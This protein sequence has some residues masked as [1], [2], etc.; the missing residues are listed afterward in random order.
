MST[1]H[2]AEQINWN[3]DDLY[4][5]LSSEAFINDKKQ[6]VELA[7]A[8][9]NKWKGT[10]ATINP[11]G[12]KLLL[13]EYSD[14][15]DLLSKMSS[16]VYLVWSTNTIETTHGKAL[17][18][19]GDLNAGL[20]QHLVFF[21]VEWVAV[22]DEK[23]NELMNASILTHEK[24]FLETARKSK[25]YMLDESAEKVMVAKTTTARQ[26]WIRFF[27]ELLGAAEFELD[28]KTL[29]EQEVLS[30]LH[31]SDRELRIRAAQSL[32]KTFKGLSRQL[33][34]I[35]NTVLQDKAANDGLRNY[36]NW[37]TSRHMSNQID[38]ATVNTLIAS[39]TASYGLV[40]RYYNLKKKLLGL[41]VM[42]DY[43]RYAPLLKIQSKITWE[44]AKNTVLDS[45]GSFDSRIKDITAKFFDNNWIDAAIKPGKRS[46][47][48][49]SSSANS[50]HP[51]VFMNY[52]GRLRDVQTL[53]H[54]LGHGVHMYLSQ[55]QGSLLSDTPL[56]TA[57]TASVF[58]EMIVF[59]Q[60]KAK[61]TDPKEKL[62]LV[63]GKIDDTI[64]TV[65]RQVSMNRFEDAIH[66]ARREEGELSIERF[67][68]L[69]RKV[70]Q[71]LYGD[72]VT[73]SPEYDLWWCYIPHFLHSP[74][75][76]YAY[77]FGE[78]LVLALYEL[79]QQGKPGF[80]DT[81][82]ELLSAGGSKKPEELVGMFGFDIQSP[83][84]WK[85]G[86]RVIESMIKEAEELATE[87]GYGN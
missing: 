20:S 87:I 12:L 78:L 80:E 53:A 10:L 81:Y 18:E 49:A 43:D 11:E 3:L 42:M 5:S 15:I 73:L 82:V 31:E 71:D 52:D 84:F 16:Y 66:T 34:F 69:W 70:Q 24:Y 4:T 61:I 22:E 1:K 68:E 33:T 63:L 50:V 37:I 13:D 59:Q 62:A 74:G 85:Q 77:A 26:A 60:L 38:D 58:G 56:T 35:F 7:K 75:Y 32:T 55:K 17:A 57:E 8:F 54:E 39:V 45:F 25:P 44:E 30:K 72:S 9:E 6:A 51:Y 2:G 40:Q 41:D 64:A 67:S 29:S 23:A 14:L 46:G 27:D 36:P 79:Y 76:V 28:G 83:E 47:A 21:D 86:I 19:I 65:Y 48:Y